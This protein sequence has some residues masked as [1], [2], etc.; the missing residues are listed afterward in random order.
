MTRG[1]MFANGSSRDRSLL[2]GTTIPRQ[3]HR[4]SCGSSR[5]RPRWRG[6]TLVT[7]RRSTGRPGGS[8]RSAISPARRTSCV[9]FTTTEDAVCYAR[10]T[11]IAPRAMTV[12]MSLGSNDGAKAWV[13]GEQVFSWY[14]GRPARPHQ[15]T[16]PVRLNVGAND[17]LVKVVNLG[18]NW[19]LYTSFDDSGR[20]LIIEAR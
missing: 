19:A 2:K 6:G 20:E 17:V 10:C 5:R 1:P 13:N 3:W 12:E 18:Y 7:T 8:V 9:T 4:G 11:V 16:V 15:D 14:G